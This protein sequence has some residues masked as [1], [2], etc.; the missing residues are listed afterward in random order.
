MARELSDAIVRLFFITPAK[1]ERLQ[2]VRDYWRKTN[3]PPIFTESEG[4]SGE[5]KNRQA[6]LSY[7][8]N[9]AASP[10]NALF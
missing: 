8:V 2:E 9:H 7:W 4:W 1:S 3:I 5:L 10:V 6:H